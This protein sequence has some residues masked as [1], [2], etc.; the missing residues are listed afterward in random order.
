V[1]TVYN[2]RQRFL[3]GG[4]E[5]VLHDKAQERRRQALSGE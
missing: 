1:G 2:A 3:T 5:A 4:L